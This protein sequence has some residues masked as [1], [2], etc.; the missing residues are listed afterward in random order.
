MLLTAD[1]AVIHTQYTH[2]THIIPVPHL[3]SVDLLLFI[4]SQCTT[5][6]KS[7]FH[8]NEC[9]HEH[10]CPW[11]VAPFQ[12]SR[13]CGECFDRHK[14]VLL[15]CFLQFVLEVNTQGLWFSKQAWNRDHFQWGFMDIFCAKDTLNFVYIFK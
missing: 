1:I 5:N 10:I 6:A 2:N 4:K 11:S 9:T 15:K 14:I 7:T 12:R 8:L 3:I 13:G